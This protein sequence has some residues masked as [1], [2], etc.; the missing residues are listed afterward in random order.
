[1]A[2]PESLEDTMRRHDMAM[3][4]WLGGFRVDYGI[5]TDLHELT[6]IDRNDFPVLRVFSTPD[7]VVASVVDTLVRTGW[8]AGTDPTLLAANAKTLREHA[9]KN[10]SVLPLPVVTIVR[11]DPVPNPTDSGVPKLFRRKVFLAQTQEWQQHRWPGAYET[12]YAVTFWCLKQYTAVFFREWVKSKL[13][14]IGCAEQE[15]LIPVVHDAPW[16]TIEQRVVYE[17]SNDLSDL[18]GEGP[19]YWRNEYT[20]RLRTWHFRPPHA[21]TSYVHDEAVNARSIEDESSEDL[22]EPNPAIAPVSLNMFSLYLPASRVPTHW[23]KRGN[24]TVKRVNGALRATMTDA[25]D[26]VLI[27]NRVVPLDNQNRAVLSFAA[28]YRSTAQVR[29]FVASRDPSVEPVT[30]ISNRSHA[31][32]ARTAPTTVQ[33][34][35]LLKQ[36]VFSVTVQGDGVPAIIYLS[37]ISL[38]HVRTQTRSLPASS[39]PSGPNVVHVWSGL[40]GGAHLLVASF[41]AGA[42]A[43]VIDVGGELY[44]V[45][46]D[47]EVGLVALFTP[48]AGAV[49]VVVPT[50]VTL[51]A[52]YV[53]PFLGSWRGTQV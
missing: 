3:H 51:D 48:T 20:F 6:P 39:T 15:C 42:M 28:S 16:G 31:L 35:T 4:E 5:S 50:A 36:P 7:R 2:Q 38:V 17:G 1:M 40:G 12:T 47:V 30:W 26:E 45:D 32:P 23:P 44:Q 19:R 33:L 43:D 52:I 14:P 8:I 11:N 24:A 25:T 27:S 37:E 22:V 9:E 29:S 41:A 21:T 10:F 34:F 13:G 53:H 49:T 46:P 18:E